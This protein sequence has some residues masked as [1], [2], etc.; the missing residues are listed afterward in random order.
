M[1]PGNSVAEV[2]RIA[3][4]LMATCKLCLAVIALVCGCGSPLEGQND[5]DAATADLNDGASDLASAEDLQRVCAPTSVSGFTPT[6]HPPHIAPGS[7]TSGEIDALFTDWIHGT[8]S[9]RTAFE[10]Q[11]AG[12][13][14]CAISADSASTSGPVI[15]YVTYRFSEANVQ[16]CIAF[17]DKDVSAT[18]CGARV[19]AARGCALASCGPVCPL[20]SSGDFAAL[21]QCRDDAGG[22]VCSS[23]VTSAS[24]A[25]AATYLP[26]AEQ[27]YPNQD[28]WTRAIVNAFCGAGSF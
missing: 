26:C 5:F 3:A 10:M 21:A 19:E 17:V 7:C 11:H 8:A 13:F 27:S 22:T 4:S 6:W 1:L 24:C 28:A 25:N 2:S 9:T 15:H 12:C 14:G 23:Y 20:H 18:S 16:G